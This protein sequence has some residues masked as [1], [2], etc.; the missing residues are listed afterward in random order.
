[1]GDA[2]TVEQLRK[3]VGKRRLLDFSRNRDNKML[4]IRALEHIQ[5]P[6]AVEL[7]Q[8]LSR[9]SNETVRARAGRALSALNARMRSGEGEER[10]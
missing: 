9:D 1:V 8:K 6:S 7:L 4:A 3:F 10:S 2:V 5:E